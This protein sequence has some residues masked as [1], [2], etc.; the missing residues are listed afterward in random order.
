MARDSRTRKEW[1]L[2]RGTIVVNILLGGM[3][4]WLFNLTFGQP[5]APDVPFEVVS[6]E[7]PTATETPELETVTPTAIFTPSA[8]FTPILPTPLPTLTLAPTRREFSE[9]TKPPY[10]FPT[11]IQI[12]PVPRV[13]ATRAR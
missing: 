1:W 6:I 5:D 4:V 13:T 3:F 9:P 12:A 11:P 10:I 2:L 7:L 8:T